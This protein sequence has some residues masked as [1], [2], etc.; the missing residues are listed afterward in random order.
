MASIDTFTTMKIRRLLE[1]MLAIKVDPPHPY[2][3]VTQAET[4][5]LYGVACEPANDKEGKVVL[6][7]GNGSNIMWEAPVAM[8]MNVTR[9]VGGERRM[10]AAEAASTILQRMRDNEETFSQEMSNAVRV[11]LDTA[12][13]V[14]QLA[15]PMSHSRLR[16]EVLERHSPVTV[17]LQT[18]EC[19]PV[20]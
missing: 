19:W 7:D 15:S 8:L 10:K 20:G 3:Y 5:I 16:I 9:E 13:P 17:Y 4:L 11:L 2:E 1:K 6:F 12:A 14:L 18:I